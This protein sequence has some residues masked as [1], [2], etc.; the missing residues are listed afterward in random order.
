MT[1][2][3]NLGQATLFPSDT[4]QLRLFAG[5]DINLG[6][7][8]MSDAPG[9]VIPTAASIADITNSLLDAAVL[10]T[11]NGGSTAL[12]GAPNYNF[13]GDLHV[14]D[15]TPASIVAGQ[16]INSLTLNVPKAADVIAGRDIVNLQY[17]GQNLNPNDITLIS[18]GRDF[19]NPP[20]D[21]PQGLVQTGVTGVV[22]VGGP[23]Q[24]DI[25]AGRDI[26]LGFSEGVITDGNLKNPN[27]PTSAGASVTLM[28]GL[29]Q[30]VDYAGFLQSVIEPSA[31]YQ[32]QLVSYVES[33]TGQSNLSTTQADSEFAAFSADQQRSFI[34][35]VFFS[36]LNTSGLDAN[37]PGGGGYALGYAAIDALFPGARAA[38]A[39]SG[40]NPSVGDLSMTYSQV[41]TLSGGGISILVP[42]GD[43]NVGL[44]N[45]PSGSGVIKAPN[46]LGIVAQ[47][48]GDVDIYTEG[49][50]NV[51]SSRIFTLG[52]G[53]IVIWSNAGNIDAGNGAKSSLSLP[54]PTT[55]VDSH[56]NE[57]LVYNAAVAGSGIRTIQDG[58]DVPAGDV[59]LIAPVGSVNA[60]DA[61]IG[62][63]GNINLSA[64]VVT[65]ASNINFG[66]TA[67]GVPPAVANVTASVSSAASS[68]S[69][70]SNAASALENTA[71]N[72]NEAAPLAQTAISWLDVFVTGLGEENCKPEDTDCLNRQKKE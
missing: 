13:F 70:T 44:A 22:S 51:N 40:S 56:G 31:T 19:T 28:A 69:A 6:A 39:G 20:Q 46:Q 64:L 71:A 23:G 21:N 1:Q 50:V 68:A 33:L 12:A 48:L 62:A 10:V 66:G 52:G 29:G 37:K 8:S 45:P 30:T 4:G 17:N 7:I 49:N 35:Q 15:P 38:A 63:A 36:Q 58:P 42:G 25:L 67:T 3:L 18:A 57:E 61:G 14:N 54:P 47:G 27:L 41:Y 2:N 59:N 5:Q 55:T 16:D 72:S 32:Q 24:L 34:D 60:G 11:D 26:N 9:S 65:G 43:I 53:N